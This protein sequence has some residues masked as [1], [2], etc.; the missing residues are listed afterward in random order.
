MVAAQLDIK[1]TFNQKTLGLYIEEKTFKLSVSC[2]KLSITD[3]FY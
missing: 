3:G 1:P 2:I